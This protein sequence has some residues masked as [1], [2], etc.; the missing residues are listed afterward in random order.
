MNPRHAD[1]KFAYKYD[2]KELSRDGWLELFHLI[3]RE[4]GPDEL[5]NV[6]VDLVRAAHL[7]RDILDLVT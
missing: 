7:R 2:G 4:L 6:L 5:C 1:K 3:R